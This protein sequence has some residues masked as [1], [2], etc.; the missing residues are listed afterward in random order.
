MFVRRVVLGLAL[1]LNMVLLYNLIWGKSGAIAYTELKERCADLE[2]RILA[3]EGEN[4]ELSR[5]IR[6]LQSDEKYL[7]KTIRNRLNFVREN[8][9][10][11]IFPDS[12][13]D[14]PGAQAHE[15]K[16]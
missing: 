3:V 13:G 16:N 1:L 9:I 7:E 6:L 8:E 12:E 2:S 11:Y 15:A 4:L 14:G 5:E 10:L